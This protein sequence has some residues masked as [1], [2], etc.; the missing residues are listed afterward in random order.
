MK[1]ILFQLK[2]HNPSTGSSVALIHRACEALEHHRSLIV[3]MLA[4]LS[5]LQA[6]GFVPAEVDLRKIE[7]NARDILDIE[8]EPQELSPLLQ[9]ARAGAAAIPDDIIGKYDTPQPTPPAASLPEYKICPR[10]G[11]RNPKVVHLRR[12]PKA[13]LQCA[14]CSYEYAFP[15]RWI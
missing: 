3:E 15:A 8:T 5:W 6:G 13:G 12:R 14:A 4:A 1:D 10:C 11:D 2:N 7:N 9:N